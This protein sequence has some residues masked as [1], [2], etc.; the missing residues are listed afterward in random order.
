MQ[1]N[2]NKLYK[3]GE[4]RDRRGKGGMRITKYQIL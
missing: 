2:F 4:L 3:S 1:R